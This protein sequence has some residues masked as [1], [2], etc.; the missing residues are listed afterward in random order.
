MNKDVIRAVKEHER[1]MAKLQELYLE[2]YSHDGF[3]QLRLEMRFM[4]KGQKEVLIN[5]GKEYRYVL[6]YE[7]SSDSSS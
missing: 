3:G 2:L 1:V 4:K 6:P 5:C 7:K